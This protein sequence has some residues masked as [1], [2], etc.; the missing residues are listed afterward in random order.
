MMDMIPTGA[1]M[2]VVFAAFTA[3]VSLTVDEHPQGH[4]IR[5]HKVRTVAIDPF[6]QYD[7]GP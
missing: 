4:I 3:L 5:T 7:L 6:A 2:I 1:V